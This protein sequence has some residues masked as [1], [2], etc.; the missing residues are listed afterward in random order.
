MILKALPAVALLLSAC[1]V[2]LPAPTQSP[3][4]TPAAATTGKTTPAPHAM[5]AAANPM[6]VDAGLEVLR[7]GGSAVD[8][9]VEVQAVLGLVEPQSSGLGGGAFMVYYDA[10]TRKVT[11]YDGR[12]TAPAAATPALFSEADGRPE[13]FRSALLSGRSTG[14]P[15]AIAMLA[16]AQ[17]D[18]GKRPWPSLFTRAA[19]LATDGFVVPPRMGAAINGRAPQA[20]A[21]DAVAYFTKPDGTRYVAG[22]TLR[23]PAYAATLRRIAAEGPAGLLDGP[24]AAAI[25]ARTHEGARP[26]AMTLADL[27]SYRPR[28]TEALCR[29]YR[30]HIVCTAATES[31]GIGLQEA[32]GIVATTD[33]DRRTPA[34]PQGW[35]QIAQASRLAYADRDYFV[36]DPAFVRL[37]VAG[38]LAPDYLA[39]RAALIGTVAGPAPDHGQ[40]AAAP[41]PG[42][43]ATVEPGGT[44]HFVIVDAAGNVVSMTTT[45]ESIFGSGRMVGGFFLN[46]QLTDFSFAPLS[47]DGT[48]AANA[49]AGGKRPR[50]SM[51]PTIILDRSR[52]FVAAAGSPGGPAIQAYNLKAIV[53]L[54]DWKLDAQ[55]AAALPNLVAR[56]DRFSGDTAMFAPATVAGLAAR[57]IT[58]RPDDRENSGVHII[59][60]RGKGY[61]G[62]AD[63]RRD[64]VAKGF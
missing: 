4:A 20:A 35:F 9:A 53:G 47:P 18:H 45:V 42:V 7:A 22:D 49:V 44:T 39:K 25:V 21:P 14:V 12:E 61:E 43:D 40:P 6:A 59:L 54:L 46:N 36:G 15:G 37:P 19:R 52:A 32:L 62:G 28:R 64:G 51:A 26:G 29:P 10:A 55:A 17:A 11:A 8:A 27:K 34:D 5:V 58:L 56:G 23:N 57:G 38:L 3:V 60:R 50:S 30:V 2:N 41:A 63:P 13:P 16:M 1:T 31:G 33:I 48:P 24:I